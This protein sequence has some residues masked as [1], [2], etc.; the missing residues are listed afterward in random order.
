MHDIVKEIT[1]RIKSDFM[2][3][4]YVFLM[5]LFECM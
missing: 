1:D 2:V 5:P 3:Q 4:F